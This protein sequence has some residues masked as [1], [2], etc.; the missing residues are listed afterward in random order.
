MT[1]IS[2]IQAAHFRATF[3]SRYIIFLERFVGQSSA[4]G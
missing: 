4:N 2:R 1:K 3:D